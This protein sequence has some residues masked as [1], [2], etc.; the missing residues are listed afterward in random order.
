MPIVFV[1]GGSQGAE[2][3]NNTI[4]DALPKLVENYQIIHQTGIK[5]FKIVKTQ[6]DIILENSKNKNRYIPIAF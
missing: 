2:I 3:I 6:A 5:N 4:L 1:L